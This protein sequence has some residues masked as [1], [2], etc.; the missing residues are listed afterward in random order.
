MP[1]IPAATLLVSVII[2]NDETVYELETKTDSDPG[3][4]VAAVQVL[5]PT[6]TE[7]TLKRIEHPY[8]GET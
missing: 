2:A 7:I 4:C 6:W 8:R 1:L 5:M 3:E